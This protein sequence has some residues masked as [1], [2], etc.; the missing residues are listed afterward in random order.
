MRNINDISNFIFIR[1]EPKKCDVIFIPGSSKYE[2]SE[3]ASDL[4]N[5]GFSK[6]ILPSG[7]FSCKL[8]SF[9]NEKVRKYK[10]EYSSDWEFCKEVLI[11]NNVPK[12]TIL[13]E[14]NS[15]NTYENAFYSKNVL[16]DLGIEVKSAIICC[17]AFH[18][19][20]VLLTYSWVFPNTKFYIV[21]IE[22]QGIN[23]ENWYKSEYGIKRVLGEMKKCGT[24]FEEYFKKLI[25]K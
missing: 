2:V 22:T 4:Y 12:E 11:R 5:R 20:R 23:K 18:S 8:E 15:T 3:K 25:D 9:P 7:K 13:C 6:F 17:Q 19:R 14:N 21:P 10:G 16:D 1:D 24:Y